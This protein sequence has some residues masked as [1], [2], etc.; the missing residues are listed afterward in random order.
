MLLKEDASVWRR[1]RAHEIMDLGDVEPPILYTA[2]VLRK[3]KEETLQTEQNNAEKN[4]I[5]SVINMKYTFPYLGSIHDVDATG[6]LVKKIQ[7]PYDLSAHIFLYE[8]VINNG[9]NQFPVVQML[10]ERQDTNSVTYWL[11]QWVRSGA[12][13]PAEVVYGQKTKA[14]DS[15]HNLLHFIKTFNIPEPNIE[16]FHDLTHDIFEETNCQSESEESFEKDLLKI[17]KDFPCWTATMVQAF[18]SNKITASSSS[19]EGDF[20]DLKHRILKHERRP[21]RIDRFLSIHLNCNEGHLKI[22]NANF[23]NPILKKQISNNNFAIKIKTNAN[24]LE[25]ANAV[26]NWRGLGCPKKRAKTYLDPCP[27]IEVKNEAHNVKNI[28]NNLLV[29]GNLLKPILLRKN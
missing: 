5:L 2:N 1:K 14:E 6:Q 16:L 9:I 7:R 23:E 15:R 27:E 25:E 24:S 20:S 10:S 19:V 18:D 8:G 29:N 28:K 11:M 12:A 26:E 4:P 21:L 13:T 17:C 3:V 22:A